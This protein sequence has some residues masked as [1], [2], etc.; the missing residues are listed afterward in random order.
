MDIS[1]YAIVGCL[2]FIVAS[3]F[4]AFF[5]RKI[6]FVNGNINKILFALVTEAEKTLGSKT[7]QA[8]LALV[9]ALFYE[10][11][12]SLSKYISAG[13]LTKLIEKAV[14]EMGNYVES[15]ANMKKIVYTDTEIREVM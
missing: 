10:R 8:K 6:G 4:I 7:G 5:S 3:F 9:I 14:V 12:P 11:Y 15:N 2:L 13:L 1:L